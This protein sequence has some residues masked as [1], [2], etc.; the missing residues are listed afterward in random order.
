MNAADAQK[1][2]FA[3]PQRLPNSLGH[4][5]GLKSAPRDF[6]PRLDEAYAIIETQRDEIA[7][8]Q[9]RLAV[10]EGAGYASPLSATL[11]HAGRPVLT[12]AQAAAQVGR[13]LATVS[14]YCASGFWQAHRLPGTGSTGGQWLIYADQALSTKQGKLP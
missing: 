9:A 12:A 11:T 5:V 14:R 2:A 13:S 8:L 4:G 7:R 1:M 10:Y 3:L 6:D